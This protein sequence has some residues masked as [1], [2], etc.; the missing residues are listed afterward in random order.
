MKRSSH[1]DA[2]GNAR[3]VDVG[4]KAPTQRVAI[5]GGWVHMAPETV[6][7][8]REGRAGK[9]DV[10]GV[11]QIAGIQA[12][13]NTS[14]LIPLCHPLLLDAVE[15]FF[16]VREAGVWIEARVRT[17]GRTGVEMEALAAVSVA[18]LT[19]Y[20]MLKSVERGMTVDGIQLLEK[21]GGRSGRW[22]RG[23]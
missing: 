9:G 23:A 14:Q 6:Q 22:E 7:V 15:V 12:A 5:A 4:D 11:A 18:A 8:I 1:L 20:D 17:S 19:V 3:M 21:D 16:D 10:L 2:H 13:K